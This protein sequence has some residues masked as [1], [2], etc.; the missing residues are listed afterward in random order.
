M[1][2]EIIKNKIFEFLGKHQVGVVSTIHANSQGTESAL[3]GFAETDNLEIIFGTSNQ[4]RKYKNIKANPHVSFVV[5]WTSIMGTIQYEG[6]AK[7]LS[8]EEVTSIA[9]IMIQK[10]VDNGKYI[11]SENQ[12]YFSVKPTWIRFLDNDGNPPDSYE[13]TF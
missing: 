2:K 10:N 6:I 1:D 9:P 7:E 8:P 3:V 13:I 4:T 12:V 11:N 5:G